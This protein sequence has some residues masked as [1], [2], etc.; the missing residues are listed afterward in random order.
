MIGVK[1]IIR[2]I[3]MKQKSNFIIILLAIFCCAT[4]CSQSYKP[5]SL[6]PETPSKAP[7]YLCTWN[8]QGYVCSYKSSVAMRHELTEQNIFGD[9]PLEGWARVFPKIH[10][11]LFLVL[12]DAWDTPLKSGDKAYYGSLILDTVRFPSVS[13]LNPEQRLA[14]VSDKVK[15]LGWKGLGLWICA[16]QAP[17]YKDEDSVQYWKERFQWMNAAG[18]RYWK[19]DWGN[20]SKKEAWRAWLTSMG[21]KWAPNLIIEHAMTP[22]VLASAATY[23]TYDVENVISIPHTIDRI[24]NLLKALPKGK[25]VS[26]I[27][28]EDEPYIAAGMGCAIGIMRHPFNGKLPNGDPDHA[29][30]LAGRDLKSRLDAEVR[31]VRWH[32]IA[33]PFGINETDFYIDSNKLH[34]FWTMRDHETYIKDH[35]PGYINA[36]DAPA[37]ITRGLDK[38]TV[39]LPR[40]DSIYPYI[41]ASKYPNGAIA[42]AAIGRTLDRQYSTPRADVLLQVDN[43]NHPFG[44][45]GH[46]DSLTIEVKGAS[47]V[48]ATRIWAQDLA[49]ETPIDITS[50]VIQRGNQF[51][52]PG[53]VIDKVGLSAATKG[54]KSE[55]GLV[56]N[57]E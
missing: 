1:D 11:D 56:L 20:E 5:A 21:K 4:G 33:T 49:G 29:F 13:R 42:I 28:C 7:D 34:D 44:I 25:A 6:V 8:L 30:P 10:K 27:N 16:Q 37:I 40:R 2:N 24:A 52:V 50:E 19:V 47:S 43:Y 36:W 46:F 17:I 31:G 22:A 45:F 32:R 53:S 51:I 3:I 18:I 15:S 48:K 54:D 55:P 9:G 12:D 57:F 39:T 26:I 38:P 23:R 35:G 41:L 14:Y